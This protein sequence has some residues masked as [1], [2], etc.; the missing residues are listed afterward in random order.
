[1][2]WRI[3]YAEWYWQSNWCE[4]QVEDSRY[5]NEGSCLSESEVVQDYKILERPG[6]SQM[7]DL[8]RNRTSWDR[9]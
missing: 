2:I 4:G 9:Y 1:M 5:L 7:P 8:R 3:A 6:L